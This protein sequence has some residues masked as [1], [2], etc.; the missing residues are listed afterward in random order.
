M[1]KLGQKINARMPDS[2]YVSVLARC[3]ALKQDVPQ[4]V[5]RAL[6]T[7]DAQMTRLSPEANG[8]RILAVQT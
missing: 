6:A 3:S 1:A 8:A 5:G 2:Y 7:V 4:V